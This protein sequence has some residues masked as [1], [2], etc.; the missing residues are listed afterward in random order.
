MTLKRS[1]RASQ[2]RLKVVKDGRVNRIEVYIV[3]GKTEAYVGPDEAYFRRRIDAERYATAMPDEEKIDLGE[4]LI[5]DALNAAN[6]NV[7]EAEAD[8]A[9]AKKDLRDL[10]YVW[11]D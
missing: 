11:K 8:L 1:L 10:L 4:V 6:A 7:A 5:V 2:V 9:E 3:R